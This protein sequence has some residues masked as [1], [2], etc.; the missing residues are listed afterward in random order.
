[1]KQAH[2]RIKEVG[3][4]TAICM[5][6]RIVPCLFVCRL[7]AWPTCR[8]C[9]LVLPTHC[10]ASCCSGF[11]CRRSMSSVSICSENSA[12]TP[13][14]TVAQQ[15]AGPKPSSSSSNP[16]QQQQQAGMQ[17]QLTSAVIGHNGSSAPG[18]SMRAKQQAELAECQQQLGSQFAAVYDYL[19]R[20]HK[21][22]M[23]YHVAASLARELTSV[24]CSTTSTHNVLGLC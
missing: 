3:T 19:L 14:S 17:Q 13:N 11:E 15:Q 7:K 21:G 20:V 4:C 1:M 12:A 8:L 23:G 6:C 2:A 16:G 5:L 22:M 10:K 18:S 9:I 24:S